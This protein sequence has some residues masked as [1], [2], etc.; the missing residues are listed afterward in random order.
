MRISSASCKGDKLILTVDIKDARRFAHAFKAGEYEISPAKKKRSLDANAY[1][2]EL[3]TKI[4][5]AIGNKTK[6]EV[7]QD[8]VTEV[9]QCVLLNLPKED[10]ESFVRSWTSKGIG[11]RV[12]TVDDCG[13]PTIMVFA[14]YG[15]SVYDTKQMSTLINWLVDECRVLDIETRPEYEIK[16]LLEAW[17]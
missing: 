14:Y 13:M 8:A 15:S 3:C 17:E 10:Y 6:E 12:Q 11:W 5:E 16:S 7:Y 1:A 9:G 2:W 4:S